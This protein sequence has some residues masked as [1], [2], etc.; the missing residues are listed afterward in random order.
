LKTN[1]HN[2]VLIGLPG[3]G[4]TSIGSIIAS[5]L[6]LV[7][8]DIDKYIEAKEQATI[9]QLFL[10]GEEHFRQLE[11]KA[12]REIHHRQSVVISTGGGIVT[13]SENMILLRKT[14]IVFYIERPIDMILT[15]LDITN[16]PL[17]AKDSHRIYTLYDERKHL[18]EQYCHFRITND[19]SMEIAADRIIQML[20]KL[21]NKF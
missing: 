11:S 7:F 6:G 19:Q 4:K 17:L 18:Y 8:C 1:T 15:S 12:T 21:A 13:R 2:I 9:P 3:S 16:R 5:I 14:G 10:R 20:K